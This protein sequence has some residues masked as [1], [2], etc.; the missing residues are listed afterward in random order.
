MNGPAQESPQV[1]KFA[2]YRRIPWTLNVGVGGGGPVG[3]DFFL[4]DDAAN[5]TVDDSGNPFVYGE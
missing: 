1:R 2:A 4:V 5:L 3:E